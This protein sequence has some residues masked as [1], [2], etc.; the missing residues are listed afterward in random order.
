MIDSLEPIRKL[1]KAVLQEP[2]FSPRLS[3]ALL[4]SILGF[5]I[6]SYSVGF[7]IG[8]GLFWA[9]LVLSFF[10]VLKKT[11]RKPLSIILVTIGIVVGLLVGLRA[12]GFVQMVN[13]LTSFSCF[14]ALL[15]IASCGQVK[16]KAWWLVKRLMRYPI[17]FIN[18]SLKVDKAV[19]S[20]KVGKRNKFIT[21]IKTIVLTFILLLLFTIILASAD[22]IFAKLTENVWKQIVGRTILSLILTAGLLILFTWR[23]S[24]ADE[25]NP[26]FSFFSFQDVF[27]PIASLVILFAVFLFVQTKYL[28]ASHEE[29]RTFDITYSEY[30]RKG[31]FE[32][33][34]ASFIGGVIS[35]FVI[36]KKN[37]LKTESK[38]VRLKFVNV[39][40]VIELFA[41]LASALKRDFMY[42]EVYGLTRTRIIGEL[43]LFWVAASLVMLMLLNTWKK[44]KEKEFLAG[45][46]VASLVVVAFLNVFNMDACIA[47]SIPSRH[48]QKLDLF[49]ISLLSEDAYDGWEQIIPKAEEIFN[50]YRV[51]TSLS[52][53]ERSQLANLDLAL[54]ALSE[55]RDRLVVKYEN[56]EEV[57]EEFYKNYEN[58]P[59]NVAVQR[60]WQSKNLTEYQVFLKIKANEDLFERRLDRL[61]EN[62]E[63][64]QVANHID[65]FKEE[66][67]IFYKFDYP[68]VN[69]K[70]K[71]APSKLHLGNL[72]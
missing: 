11:K 62:I 51:K 5:N 63:N 41:L 72:K 54:Q 14:I 45:V 36:L 55:K 35:Y 68:F 34:V 27:I 42:I 52:K 31:F 25:K 10:M 23:F 43:F 57:K 59:G 66:Y 71:Y 40:L 33:I 47:K 19:R 60:K 49:Y 37:V 53:E 20:E 26:K 9:T 65:L 3:W 15:L 22:P 39:I 21:Y 7:G 70:L 32:L 13:L 64:Y 8:V 30:V 18:Q 28:F 44:V 6:F 48:R 24:E 67:W 38:K 46:C 29:F 16:W 61:I 12:N 50:S 56:Q 2:Y 1:K 4:L 58:I 17:Y 69:R